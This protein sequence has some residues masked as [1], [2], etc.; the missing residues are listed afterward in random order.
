MAVARFTFIH[1]VFSRFLPFLLHKSRATSVTLRPTCVML[2]AA[3]KLLGISRIP[4]VAEL[5]VTITDT[6][7]TNRDVLDTVKVPSCN[8]R[9]LSCHCHEMAEQC[10]GP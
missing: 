3:E 6:S 8:S 4:L 2:T 10:L 9:V 1:T 7:T 5:G